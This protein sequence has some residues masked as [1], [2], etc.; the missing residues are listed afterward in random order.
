MTRFSSW[1]ILL[2]QCDENTMQH[3]L[4]LQSPQRITMM[5]TKHFKHHMTNY[6]PR[7]LDALELDLEFKGVIMRGVS[8]NSPQQVTT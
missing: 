1:P 6:K 4:H 7:S 2:L 5:H 8:S 3:L